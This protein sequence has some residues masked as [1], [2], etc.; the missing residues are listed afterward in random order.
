MS[1][2]RQLCKFVYKVSALLFPACY[3]MFA[4]TKVYN[5][6]LLCAGLVHSCRM[7]PER[8]FLEAKRAKQPVV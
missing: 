5:S 1:D 3:G 4:Q 7:D 8:Q 2:H 6:M